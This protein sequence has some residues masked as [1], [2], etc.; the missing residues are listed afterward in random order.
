MVLRLLVIFLFDVFYLLLDASPKGYDASLAKRAYYYLERFS[1]KRALDNVYGFFMQGIP[2]HRINSVLVQHRMNN[3]LFLSKK[4]KKVLVVA[5]VSAGKSTL[6]NALTGFRTRQVRTTVC[7]S[8][9]HAV[10]NKAQEDGISF[11][12]ED[13]F[14]GYYHNVED[15]R[16]GD[17]IDSA[18]HFNSTLSDHPICFIDSPGLNYSEDVTHR[19]LTEAFVKKQSYDM[20][21][22][23]ANSQYCG[24]T[25]EHI[26]LTFLRENTTK[27]IIFVLNQL[28]RFKQKDESIAKMVEDF[29]ADLIKMG[30]RAP[31]VVPLSARAALLFKLPDEC[32]DEEDSEEKESFLCQFRKPYYDL[33][34]YVHNSNDSDLLCRTGI[35][36]LE[37]AIINILYTQ[38]Q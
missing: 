1:S 33:V 17:F 22:Y 34:S 11:I 31:L 23:I 27:P 9:I 2:C 7:T 14:Y 20:V 4:E 26:T 32:L 37:E 30:F 19:S 24:T 18:Y 15:V 10:F 28:D 35:K 36:Y 25:D 21:V 8:K 29:R 13:G 5:N 3:D 12:R 38:F 6:I 16:S